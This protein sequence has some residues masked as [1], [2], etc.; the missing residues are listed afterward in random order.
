[1]GATLQDRK[2]YIIERLAVLQDEQI[3]QLIESLLFEEATALEDEP[4]ND[5]ETLLVNER[6]AAYHAE[7][8]DEI[9]WETVKAS[10]QN[11]DELRP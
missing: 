11:P 4:L 2:L 10:L 5:G 8:D 1:M 9:P 6:L 3:I 7:P